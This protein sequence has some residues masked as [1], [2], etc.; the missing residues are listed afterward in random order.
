MFVQPLFEVGEELV[1][2]Y[3]ARAPPPQAVA[4][5]GPAGDDRFV[6]LA[7]G[8]PLVAV[9]PPAQGL[10]EASRV[11]D[12]AR[13]RAE[14]PGGGAA[15]LGDGREADRGLLRTGAGGGDAGWPLHRGGP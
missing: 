12:V 7:E 2:A 9:H 6:L 14:G 11:P 10:L 5:D 3:L 15:G 1:P 8:G 13:E 4:F